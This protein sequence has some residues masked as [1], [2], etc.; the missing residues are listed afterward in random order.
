MP[1]VDPVVDI[2]LCPNNDNNNRELRTQDGPRLAQQPAALA[3]ML[4]SWIL[5][6]A[7]RDDYLVVGGS[8][9]R[10]SDSLQDL[11]TKGSR[12]SIHNKKSQRTVWR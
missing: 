6:D 2:V 4:L 3:W 10:G 1:L 7:V 9:T 12:I 11:D 8:G 5:L